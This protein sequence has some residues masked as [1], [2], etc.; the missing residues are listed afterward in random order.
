MFRQLLSI[1]LA[2]SLLAGCGL[3]D[4]DGAPA[5]GPS[6]V[7]GS[8][9]SASASGSQTS[10]GSVRVLDAAF[11]T[12]VDE[13]RKAA[14]SVGNVFAPD[15]KRVY[16][17]LVLEGASAG[18][19][20]TGRWYKLDSPSAPPEGALI[21]QAGIELESGMVSP[22]GI[23]RVALNLTAAGDA[24][25]SGQWL[26]RVYLDEAAIRT[27]AFIVLPGAAEPESEASPAGTGSAGP[28]TQVPPPAV[29]GT[30]P[31]GEAPAATATIDSAATLPAPA[32]TTVAPTSYTVQPGD[33]LTLIAERVKPP[34]ESTES[35]VTRLM[36]ANALTPASVL[37]VGQALTLPGPL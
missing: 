13:E 17:V 36:E 2:A 33:T 28:A 32:A 19:V 4:G 8:A 6:G 31:A 7:A 20:V 12:E 16:A 23:A 21:D 35:Y 10:P 14:G 26:V 15:T 37:A 34:G 29:G 18:D 5:D 25:A 9:T 24:L 1:S 3:L 22:D 11:G 27:M 30:G